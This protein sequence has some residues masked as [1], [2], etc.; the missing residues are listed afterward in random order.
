[1]TSLM[2]LGQN[3]IH[4]TLEHG[5]KHTSIKTKGE[6]VLDDANLYNIVNGEVTIQSLNPGTHSFIIHV[7]GYQQLDTALFIGKDVHNLRFS[8]YPLGQKL[9]THTVHF[10]RPDLIKIPDVRGTSIYTGKKAEIFRPKE[11]SANL[12]T[13]NAR[14]IY[15]SIPGLNIW[16]NDASGLQLNIGARGLDPNRT[17]NF[18]TRQNGHDISAD[19]LGYPETY[20]T[21]PSEAVDR[22]EFVRGAA[23]LQY[24]PHFGGL[25]N[26]HIKDHEDSR[27]GVRQSVT[28][29]SFGFFQ[30]FT[31]VGGSS[32][33]HRYYAFYQRKSGE[34]YRPNSGFKQNTAFVSFNQKIGKK[35]DLSLTYTHMDYLAQQPG[36]LVDFEFHQDPYQSKRTRN[37]FN[38]DWNIASANLNYRLGDSTLINGR[39]FYLFACRESVGELSRPHRPDPMR[40]RD[41]ISGEFHNLG[42]E[43][44]L[45]HSYRFL[46]KRSKLLVGTRLYRGQTH[47]KQGFADSTSEA[48]FEFLNPQ[49]VGVSDYSFPAQNYAFFAENMIELSPSWYIN[50]GVRYEYIHTSV[51]GFYKNRLISGDRVIFSES[52]P[53]Q[54]N[55]NRHFPL[56]GMGIS[57]RTKSNIEWIA[58]VTQNYK[59]INFSD[60]SISNPNLVVDSLLQDE[61]GFNIDLGFRGVCKNKAIWFDASVF[62]LRYN[63]RIGIDEISVERNGISQQTAFRTNIGDAYSTG[64]ESYA[65]VDVIRL[66]KK[67]KSP[68]KINAFGNFSYV[69]GRYIS[70]ESAFIGN[71]I[72]YVVPVVVKSGLRMAWNH[73]FVTYQFSYQGEQFTDAT[74]AVL[75]TDGTR[76]VIPEFSIHDINAGWT[77]NQFS[78]KL[79]INNV[80][81]RAYFTRRA[82][83]YPGPGIIPAEPR[84]VYLSLRYM[85]N[86]NEKHV[87]KK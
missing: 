54:R 50:P 39:A 63:N 35:A 26:Y 83:S 67:N 64:L 70:G 52:I 29:G 1:M 24:G 73:W 60:M 6:L 45:L 86:T 21:P 77:R 33:K 32:K 58:N 82:L 57:H 85:F 7:N 80:L 5:S 37:W 34:Q 56:F 87:R 74:N 19:A 55:N 47:N 13:N 43:W 78:A 14:Q 8:L 15:Q 16:E 22:I 72:E 71:Q 2:A 48:N 38:V 12:A 4:I 27:L 20:Y 11:T 79:S 10:E 44:R 59:A 17:S 53:V 84:S 25:L 23:S 36:G 62:Y 51:E 69:H 76:G 31:S 49:D 75:V 41:M 3:S 42:T 66:L 68:W 40:Q 61:S 30:S 28:L 46:S 9:G 18:N 81:N 65:N